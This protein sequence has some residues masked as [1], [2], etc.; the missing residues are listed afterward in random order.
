MGFKCFR[1]ISAVLK[2]PLSLNSLFRLLSV[3]SATTVAFAYTSKEKL[4]T[5][6]SIQITTAHVMNF[7]SIYLCTMTT[8]YK[9]V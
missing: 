2:K 1:R 7:S 3:K 9:L 8:I 5:F 4:K 6:W